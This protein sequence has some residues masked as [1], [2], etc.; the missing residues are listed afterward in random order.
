MRS[1]RG[2]QPTNNDLL[3]EQKKTAGRKKQ[4]K[5]GDEVIRPYEGKSK[6]P[7]AILDSN[8]NVK[9]QGEARHFVTRHA[10]AF[11][12]IR[13]FKGKNQA[14]KYS[15]VRT[16]KPYLKDKPEHKKLFNTLKE[17]EIPG[18]Y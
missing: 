14:I 5:L 13:V 1:A 3:N 12:L 10:N 2:E 9:K 11:K 4:L 8:G 7:D 18:A 15:L 16:I 6:L 17:R